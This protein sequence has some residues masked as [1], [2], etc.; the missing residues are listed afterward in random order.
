MVF[1]FMSIILRFQERCT[2]SI[3]TVIPWR[4]ISSW[5]IQTCSS[6][7][8]RYLF[9]EK[10]L[11]IQLFADNDRQRGF[12][13]FVPMPGDVHPHSR[14]TSTCKKD[15][16]DLDLN[17]I[18][19]FFLKVDWLDLFVVGTTPMICCNFYFDMQNL[20]NVQFSRRIFF[21]LCPV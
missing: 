18:M 7:M 16:C 17:R 3:A 8:I 21:R 20:W 13:E 6:N 10:F 4:T 15:Y 11:L 9:L 12:A 14:W 5:Q 1:E 2:V 19:L